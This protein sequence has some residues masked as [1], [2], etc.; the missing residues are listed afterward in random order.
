MIGH[1]GLSP[2]DD[3]THGIEAQASERF[4][5]LSAERRSQV[6]ERLETERWSRGFTYE[7]DG[8]P[9]LI[10]L[11]TMPIVLSESL[12]NQLYELAMAARRVMAC[13]PDLWLASPAVRRVMPLSV[14]E[15]SWI[16]D[17]WSPEHHRSQGIISRLD[18]DIKLSG[19]GAPTARF[20]EYNGVAVGGLYYAEVA[21]ALAE[22][23]LLPALGI[24]GLT[25]PPR[26]PKMILEELCRQGT[27]I[28]EPA[29]R[30]LLLENR[31]WDSGI[32]EAPQF[33]RIWR[34][35][36]HDAVIGDPRDLEIRGDEICHDGI[37]Y[38][39]F[40]RHMEV[41]DLLDLE[42]GSG[43]LEAVRRAFRENRVVSSLSG[44]FD[45]KAAWEVVA[46][47][48]CAGA[49]PRQDLSK[50]MP[51][52]PWTRVVR[53]TR[54]TVPGGATGDLLEYVRASRESLVIK[55]NRECGGIGVTLGPRTSASEWGSA[56]DRALQ[57]PGEWVAQSLVSNASK[58]FPV[59]D[60]QA[61]FAVSPRYVAY[62]FAATAGGLGC[63]G[64]Y[65]ASRVVNVSMGGGI[66]PV[67][68]AA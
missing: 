67:M 61:G 1:P 23:V 31:D 46:D 66:V 6:L 62:G 54:T 49:F 21:E 24:R 33:V 28:G 64:R 52:I 13:L 9:E 8:K 29:R 15:E 58:R 3:D 32:T 43:R 16:R 19:G 11:G 37:A 26:I 39:L 17:T 18:A 63:L 56:V 25:R 7:R 35:L 36:G 55:P 48:E 44:E 68:R 12:A 20:F 40:Y 5:A 30:I 42:A 34:E 53:A 45:H 50:I 59:P 2:A 27:S 57:A 41:R 51:H 22:E 47:P 65:S 38:D 14:D 10:S 4:L 60:A